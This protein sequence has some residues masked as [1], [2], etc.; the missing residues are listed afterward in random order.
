MQGQELAESEMLCGGDVD[1]HLE[2][3]LAGDPLA[4]ELFQAAAGLETRGERGLMVTSLSPGPA[5]TLEG[6]KALVL[7]G[8]QVLGGL[9]KACDLA[10][11]S[12]GQ[13]GR[14]LLAES[15][16]G[17]GADLFLEPIYKRPCVFLMG[18][19]HISLHLAALIK[20]VGFD[21]VVG[22]DR[23]EFA[24][25]ARFP[26][27]DQI[28]L[29][30]FDNILAGKDLG[31]QAFVVIITRGHIHD[32]VVLAQALSTET[33]YVG[34][35]GSRRKRNIIY[36]ALEDEGFSAE[37]IGRVHSPVGLDIGAETPEEIAVS[38]VAEL[39]QVRA[40]LEG[41]G[42]KKLPLGV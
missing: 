20:T 13:P 24:N 40:S 12:A 28:W 37:A 32:K 42:G 29:A 25:R 39:I 31:P 34:M 15:Q 1:V 27:A 3:I 22:E 5:P 36:K 18:G 19:G 35:I 9:A 38:I 2:P 16:P 26:M 33:A 17:Q 8:G 41:R 11:L 7:P 14:P 4:R 10:A 21:L 23:P 6:R 30:D